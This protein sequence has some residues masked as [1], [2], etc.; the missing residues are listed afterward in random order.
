MIVLK[1]DRPM[2]E[3]WWLLWNDDISIELWQQRVM[4][5]SYHVV[6]NE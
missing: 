4:I 2:L 3:L 6:R 5:S 1:D